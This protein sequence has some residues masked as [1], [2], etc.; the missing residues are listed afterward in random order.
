[1]K[2]RLLAQLPTGPNWVYE[3]K[4]D[5]YRGL[6][7]K[8]GN[9]VRLLSRN[10]KDLGSRF[11]GIVRGLQKLPC[12]RIV[13]DGEVVALDENGRG[14]FQLLQR[15][16]EPGFKNAALFYYAFD[17]LNL[18]GKDTTRLPLV[19]RKALLKTV[20]EN[21]SDCLRFSGALHGSPEE[22]S[23]TMQHLGLEGLIAK[24]RDSAYEIGQRSGAW[25]KFKWGFE[26]EFVIGGYTD[27][28]GSRPY[29]GSVLVGYYA[30][31]KLIFAA[32]VGTGFDAKLLK[33]LYDRFQKIR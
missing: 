9:E 26:Q 8:D 2:C 14:S 22:L 32:K 1:M 23:S 33:S 28:E 18:N 12:E 24:R 13:L 31:A 27:P 15:A 19:N 17:L 21:K 16:N 11:P 5:G 4:F 29:F 7:I 30:N 3:I 25:V 10:D 20:L 6:A